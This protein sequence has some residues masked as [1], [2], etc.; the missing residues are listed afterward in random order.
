MFNLFDPFG[1]GK[2][3]EELMAP[4]VRPSDNALTKKA[5]YLA[6]TEKNFANGNTG[7]QILKNKLGKDEMTVK[8][9]LL[10]LHRRGIASATSVC[11][12]KGWLNEKHDG[13]A[14]SMDDLM[15]ILG[16]R[17]DRKRKQREEDEL[18]NILNAGRRDPGDGSGGCSGDGDGDDD[19]ELEELD[20]QEP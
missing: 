10:K 19:E 15:S 2:R 20:D 9:M 14:L 7:V 13:E 6:L 11:E 5:I 3:R 18:I 16:D 4:Y 8:C 17:D 1:F 12:I